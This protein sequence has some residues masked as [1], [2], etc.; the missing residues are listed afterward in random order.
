[1]QCARIS[2]PLLFALLL[3][4][5]LLAPAAVP[6]E[7]APPAYAEEQ[8]ILQAEKELPEPGYG[9]AASGR[10]HL[11]RHYIVPPGFMPEQDMIL[12]RGGNAWRVLRNGPFATIS[13]VLV[14]VVPLLLLLFY[15][16][17]GPQRIEHP[18]TGRKIRRFSDWDRFIHW[19]TAIA[20]L[21]MAA[22]GL[23]VLF[24]KKVLLPWMGHAAFSWLAVISKYLHNFVGP[25]FIVCSLMLFFNFLHK[26][27]FH[28]H[29]W[30]W[31]R[32]A[33]G[34]ISHEHVPAGYFNPGEKLWFWGGLTLLG[35]V[36]SLTGLMLDFPYFITT[37]ANT[38]F[39]RYLL[40]MANYFHLAGATLYIIA[41]MGH[42]YLGTLGTPGAY[43]A[44]RY[45][46][47]DE[48][49][50]RTHHELWYDEVRAEGRAPVPPG[51]PLPPGASP[52]PGS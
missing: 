43:Q 15:R 38:G 29:D 8:T 13:G 19:T 46:T 39:T 28:R 45:G 31:F 16:A 52:R 26:N 2:T 9:D 18:E 1:M 35:L 20:F 42:I 10:A 3:L 49:W 6:N 50:A 40:Q 14:L 17:F 27:R 36:M 21:T 24:G 11:D 25:L 4:L 33:G 34:M 12:Q 47:V 30:V 32:K 48:E 44:M 7:S 23:I 37:G 5:P 22:T 51:Q 41:A